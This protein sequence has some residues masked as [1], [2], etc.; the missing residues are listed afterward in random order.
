MKMEKNQ[1]S[2]NELLRAEQIYDQAETFIRAGDFISARTLL[3]EVIVIN[4]YFTYAYLLLSKIAY[5]NGV[6]E[7]AIKTIE[8]C[9]QYDK[10]F[11]YPYFLM[12]KYMSAAGR[13]EEAENMIEAGLKIDRKNVLLNRVKHYS[14]H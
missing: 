3:K 9:F 2:K 10:G 12:A 6:V 4:P 8:K 7:E 1:T 11:A 13:T 14:R 5:K